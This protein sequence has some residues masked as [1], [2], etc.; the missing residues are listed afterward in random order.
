LRAAA[1]VAIEKRM[2]M[3]R[4]ENGGEMVFGLAQMACIAANL[5]DARLTEELINWMAANYWTN[6]L[7]SLHN[8]GNLFNMDLSCGFPAAIMRALVYS[9]PGLLK[10]LPALPES[11]PE[12]QIEGILARGQIE[13]GQLRWNKNGL[14]VSLESLRT[15]SV[16]LKLPRPAQ[17]ITFQKGAAVRRLTENATWRVELPAAQ[18]VTTR[19]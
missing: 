10:L 18:T 16:I 19:F 5:G 17:A 9:E 4:R 14:S 13:V 1:R 11:W 2:E 7:A 3:R 15:Q 8:P 12:G 6:S